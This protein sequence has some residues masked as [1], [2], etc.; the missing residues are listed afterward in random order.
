MAS[1]L[2]VAN[3]TTQVVTADSVINPGVIIRR[4]AQSQA[5][6]NGTG[7]TLTGSGYFVVD[8]NVTFTAPVAGDIT[9]QLYKDGVAVPGA[10]ATESIATAATEVKS[11]SFS[12]EV[13]NT[14]CD[15]YSTLTLVNSSISAIYTNVSVRVKRDA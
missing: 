10:T 12:V 8:V 3:T 11:M 7:I 2:Y 1:V 13:R 6:L 14:C 4:T 9:V 5:N 15:N